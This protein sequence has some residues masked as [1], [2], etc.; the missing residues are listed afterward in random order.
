MN[1]DAQVEG[2]LAPPIGIASG[3]TLAYPVE[4]LLVMADGLADQQFAGLFEG[5]ANPLAPGTSPTPVLPA[6]SLTITIL[7]VKNGPWAP[8]RLSSMLS[9]PATG[10]TCSRVMSGVWPG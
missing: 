2:L 10:T 7:R 8:L 1:G 4:Q 5:R 9:C 3:K 6:L